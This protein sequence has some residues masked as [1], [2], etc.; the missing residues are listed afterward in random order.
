[1]NKF[2]Y[3]LLIGILLGIYTETNYPQVF[4]YWYAESNDTRFYRGDK[5]KIKKPFYK[6]CDAVYLAGQALDED[7]VAWILL[8]NCDFQKNSVIFPRLYTDILSLKYLEK[9]K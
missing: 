8:K 2:L 3:G 9:L 1:M 4:R 5:L 7:N 6:G